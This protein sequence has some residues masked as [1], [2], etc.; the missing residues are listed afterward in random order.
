MV[1]PVPAVVPVSCSFCLVFLSSELESKSKSGVDFSSIFSGSHLIL[2]NPISSFFPVCFMTWLD[3]PLLLQ[4]HL[5]LPKLPARKMGP[6]TQHFRQNFA[7]TSRIDQR[8]Q[9]T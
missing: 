6:F 8:L 4:E 5:L 3:L 2:M 7:K 1:P 9:S